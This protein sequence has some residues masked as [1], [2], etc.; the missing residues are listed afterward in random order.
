MLYHNQS[1]F[2]ILYYPPPLTSLSPTTSQGLIRPDPAIKTTY[3]CSEITDQHIIFACQNCY[4]YSW[5]AKRT[6]KYVNYKY[7]EYSIYKICKLFLNLFANCHSTRYTDIFFHSIFS[8]NILGF[9][10]MRILILWLRNSM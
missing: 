10:A 4:N 1:V 8:I 6:R 9:E 7:F 3:I 5:P 2:Y